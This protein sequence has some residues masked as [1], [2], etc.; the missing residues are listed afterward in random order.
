[1]AFQGHIK[2]E[3]LIAKSFIC[4]WADD[5][6]KLNIYKKRIN[7]TKYLV[8]PILNVNSSQT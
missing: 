8:Y 7:Y 6:F 2:N 5:W 1:M 4:H 3:S